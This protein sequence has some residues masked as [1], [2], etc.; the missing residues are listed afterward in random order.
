MKTTLALT[1]CLLP[2]CSSLV[3]C[4][5]KGPA[6]KAGESIDK[7]GENIKDAVNPKGP[8]EKAGEK[9][10]KALGH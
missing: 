1:L 8:V 5:E 6:E 7:A 2:F 10:D 9:V 4:K 3:S